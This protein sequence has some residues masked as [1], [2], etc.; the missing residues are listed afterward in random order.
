MKA[1]LTAN[2]FFVKTKVKGGSGALS[3]KTLNMADMRAQDIVYFMKEG[4]APADWETKFDKAKFLK[5]SVG[6]TMKLKRSKDKLLEDQK[7]AV[8]YYYMPTPKRSKTTAE[9][10]IPPFTLGSWEP[11]PKMKQEMEEM[12]VVRTA[13]DD[14]PRRK[15]KNVEAIAQQL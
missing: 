10:N 4:H 3:A 7:P 6:P 12:Q 13:T 1:K 2:T 8:P 15:V 9:L 5:Y 11:L 14:T